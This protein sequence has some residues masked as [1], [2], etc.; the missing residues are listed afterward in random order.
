MAGSVFAAVVCACESRGRRLLRIMTTANSDLEE[1]VTPVLI[2]CKSKLGRAIVRNNTLSRCPL[3]WTSERWQYAGTFSNHSLRRKKQGRGQV[4]D[5]QR[6]TGSS[7]R[8]G[9]GC[10]Y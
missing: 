4:W 7:S 8:T 3:R 10:G 2:L 1:V 5:W 6:C 9:A